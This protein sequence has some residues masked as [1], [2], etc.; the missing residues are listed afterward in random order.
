MITS[1]LIET[2]SLPVH[3][4]SHKVV[5]WHVFRAASGAV[6]YAEGIKLGEGQSIVGGV[7]SDSIGKL[8]WVGVEVEEVSRWGNLAAVNKHAE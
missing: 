7:D 1:I 5:L 2:R 3:D 6:E 8:W 4:A